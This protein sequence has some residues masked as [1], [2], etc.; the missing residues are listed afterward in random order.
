M[1]LDWPEPVTLCK[2]WSW[3]MLML[4]IEANR[5]DMKPQAKQTNPFQL[6]ALRRAGVVIEDN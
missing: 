3:F 4:M 1:T 5:S 2:S 6:E